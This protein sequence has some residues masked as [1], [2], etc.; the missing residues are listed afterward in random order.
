MW[1]Y[2]QIIKVL[3]FDSGKYCE[4]KKIF[5]GE[6]EYKFIA[7]NYWCLQKSNNVPF[8]SGINEFILIA[9]LN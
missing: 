1:N 6:L 7:K 4:G 3:I 5:L 9:S 2:P 8:V